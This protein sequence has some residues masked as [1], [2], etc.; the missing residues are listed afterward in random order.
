MSI[1]EELSSRIR[2]AFVRMEEH[3][4]K[5][6]N[7]V[8]LNKAYIVAGMYTEIAD[9]TEVL[10]MP[11]LL[12]NHLSDYNYLIAIPDPNKAEEVWLKCFQEIC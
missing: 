4:R 7:K 11:V 9:V 12:V 6:R 2:E 10:G 3:N 1:V 5:Y 8:D